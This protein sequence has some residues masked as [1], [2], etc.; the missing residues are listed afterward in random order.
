MDDEEMQ[1]PTTRAM[2]MADGP[3]GVGKETPVTIP[4]TITYG[5]QNT[6]TTILP[7]TFFLGS[8]QINGSGITFQYQLNSLYSPILSAI[9]TSPTGNTPSSYTNQWINKFYAANITST[10][11]LG[12]WLE[13]FPDAYDITT[14]IPAYRSH[15]DGMYGHY[16]VLGVEYEI[17]IFNLTPDF[18]D[19]TNGTIWDPQHLEVFK[20]YT[21]NNAVPSSAT[22]YQMRFWK[23]T[24]KFVSYAPSKFNNNRSVLSISG[25][26]KPG[27]VKRDI[28][29]DSEAK[30]WTAC[31]SSPTL[32]E[33]IYLKIFPQK[34]IAASG[35]AA[36]GGPR[37]SMECTFKYIVQ[38]KGLVASL[39]YPQAALWS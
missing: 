10:G 30:V 37:V 9:V 32:K 20:L 35:V 23:N 31:G 17:R 4:P 12:H 11:T 19:V 5:H 3:G 39:E 6:H 26:W 16:T 33:N 8:G 7:Y 21:S 29:D 18:N 36:E 14:S 38:F 1:Q 15:W 24:D 34:L 13:S 25:V 2:T 22:P 27:D 28:R